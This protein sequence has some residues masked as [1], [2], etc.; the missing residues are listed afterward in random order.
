MAADTNSFLHHKTLDPIEVFEGLLHLAFFCL[1]PEIN[2]FIGQT[3]Q[4]LNV[5]RTT[6]FKFYESIFSLLVLTFKSTED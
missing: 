5:L 3:F 2:E 6:H 1:I 4:I